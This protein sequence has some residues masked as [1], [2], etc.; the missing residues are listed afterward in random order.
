MGKNKKKYK[1]PGVPLT[2]E[3][4]EESM[5][6][7]ANIPALSGEWDKSL[8]TLAGLPATHHNPGIGPEAGDATLCDG[9]FNEPY[10]SKEA[11]QEANAPIN[12]TGVNKKMWT[13]ALPD[14]DI[15]DIKA[16]E[17]YTTGIYTDKGLEAMKKVK[18]GPNGPKPVELKTTYDDM[19]LEEKEKIKEIQNYIAKA[20]GNKAFCL[21]DAEAMKTYKL[22]ATWDPKKAQILK[23]YHGYNGKKVSKA[24][25]DEL[26]AYLK[27][28]YPEKP[29]APQYPQYEEATE[30]TQEYPPDFKTEDAKPITAEDMKKM[31]DLLNKPFKVEPDKIICHPAIWQ[32]IKDSMKNVTVEGDTVTGSMQW[33]GPVGLEKAGFTPVQ[34]DKIAADNI[35]TE[36]DKKMIEA[37][38][39]PAEYISLKISL[40]PARKFPDDDYKE[41]L[42]HLI[43]D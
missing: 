1:G 29:A 25:Y 34:L 36:I 32:E 20:A 12:E 37:L 6:L 2:K 13:G 41:R 38:Q 39:A 7:I 21:E 35:A 10:D 16:K 31:Y 24:N 28:L 33:P 11:L 17:V 5:D 26:E 27:E 22:K 40:T 23:A 3:V 9:Q 8:N 30:F 4:Y 19:S 18:Y 14:C 43:L 42:S 15:K